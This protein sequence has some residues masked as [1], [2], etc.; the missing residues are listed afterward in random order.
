MQAQR[1]TDSPQGARIIF[2]ASAC[3]LLVYWFRDLLT[4][5]SSSE[6]EIMCKRGRLKV[7]YIFPQN[8]SQM[9]NYRML[10]RGPLTNRA[11]GEA[12]EVNVVGLQQENKKPFMQISSPRAPPMQ[13]PQHS[14][15]QVGSCRS[16]SV[17]QVRMD[18]RG[19]R[20]LRT[21]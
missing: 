18:E 10:R 7:S 3:A 12:G 2:A 4:P 8:K 14:R 13:D 17:K 19:K 1:G 20:I 11:H 9:E 21:I 5:F 16:G 15:R 6:L